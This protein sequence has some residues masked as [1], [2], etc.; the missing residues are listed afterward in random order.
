MHFE[1]KVECSSSFKP[2][3]VKR[4]CVTKIA[5]SNVEVIA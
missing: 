2:I 5:Q 4:A 3:N 1:D